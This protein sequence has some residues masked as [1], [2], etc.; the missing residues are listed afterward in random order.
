[1]RRDYR[2][3]EFTRALLLF[4]MLAAFAP[5]LADAAGDTP[6]S[7]TDPAAP[8]PSPPTDTHAWLPGSLPYRPWAVQAG[9]GYNLVTGSAGDYIHGRANAALGITW[10]PSPALPIALRLDGSYGW[11]TPGGQLLRSGGVGYNAGERDIYGSD[12]DLQLDVAHPSLRQK[13]YLLA[14]VGEYRV[15]TSLQKLSNAPE[16]C[17]TRFCGRFPD[18][19]ATE[20][21]TSG[22]DDSWNAGIGWALALDT[23]TW[24]FIEARYEHVFTRGSD[25]QFMPIRVGLRF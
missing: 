20:S 22:W 15:S 14:G 10:F 16:V 6:D 5:V 3:G 7:S 18:V 19:L 17:G 2:T 21:D 25:T 13:F 11:F 1:M 9:G 8:A 12:L 23:H 4:A 24:V